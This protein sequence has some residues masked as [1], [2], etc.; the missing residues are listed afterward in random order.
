[1]GAWKSPSG[2]HPPRLTHVIIVRPFP[3]PVQSLAQKIPP[4]PSVEE[5]RPAFCPKCGHPARAPSRNRLGIIG[6][7]VYRRQVLGFPSLPYAKRVIPVRRYLCLGCRRTISVLPSEIHPYRWYAAPMI[8]FGLFQRLVLGKKP[9]E[10]HRLLDGWGEGRGWKTLRRWRRDL[11]FKL[12]GWWAPRLGFR[13][14][15]HTQEEGACRLGRLLGQGSLHPP[16]EKV[17]AQ[18]VM[19]AAPGLLSWTWHWERV[20]RPL[21]HPS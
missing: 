10:V 20:G 14:E 6:H 1:M 19:A 15:A 18:R 2:T 7:G 4:F 11:L 8:L 12:W 9:E 13:G 5:H 21:A 3:V 17:P 16:W